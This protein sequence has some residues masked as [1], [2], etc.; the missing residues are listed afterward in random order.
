[1]EGRNTGTEITS[2]SSNEHCDVDLKSAVTVERSR[3][4][5][6]KTAGDS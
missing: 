1:M 6:E 5:E 3:M 2:G 4:S